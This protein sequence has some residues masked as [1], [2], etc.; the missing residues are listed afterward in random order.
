MIGM[1]MRKQYEI[2][3]TRFK[4]KR[5]VVERSRRLVALEKTTIDKCA[6]VICLDHGTGTGNG[7]GGA[8]K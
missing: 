2:N 3:A 1:C 7:S 6:D 8:K 5:L 4:G